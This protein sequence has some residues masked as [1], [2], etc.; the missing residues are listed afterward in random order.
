MS[1]PLSAFLGDVDTPTT[2]EV[3]SRFDASRAFLE[4]ALTEP[5]DGPTIVVTH[6]LPSL[7]S[8]AE[9]FRANPVS[10]GFASNLDDLVDRGATLWVHG[11]THDS[12]LWR[13]DGGTLV[14][15]NPAGYPRQGGR[16][17]ENDRFHPKL[18]F[19]IR[20]A[21]ARDRWQADVEKQ[22]PPA[23]CPETCGQRS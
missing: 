5:F 1:R 14:A 4:H 8:V 22:Q 7:R 17:Q 15:C 11:H 19:V 12:C 2:S 6:H 23:G 13:S 21:A 10:A 9:R 3:L 16:Q 20:R 18:V